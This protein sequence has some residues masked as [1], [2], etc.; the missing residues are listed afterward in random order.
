MA[1]YGVS[2]KNIPEKGAGQNRF[3]S[4]YIAG[5]LGKIF[6]RSWLSEQEHWTTR[7]NAR[8]KQLLDHWLSY[9]VIHLGF[10]NTNIFP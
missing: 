6:I 10:Q 9:R 5:R 2:R 8:L 3:V 4:K 7:K 1:K